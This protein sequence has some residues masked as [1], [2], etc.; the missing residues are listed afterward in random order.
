MFLSFA[1]S[2]SSPVL[3]G[4]AQAQEAPP[5]VGGRTTSDYE[6]VGLLAICDR[7]YWYGWYCSGT[8][9]HEDWV[10]TAAHCVEAGL[11]YKQREGLDTCFALGSNA[12]SNSGIDAVST[13]Q[14]MYAHPSYNSNN[15]SNDVGLLELKTPLRHLDPMA[16]NDDTI[17]NS[18]VGED[19]TW[20]GWGVTRQTANDSGVKRTVDVPIYT[21]DSNIVYTYAEGV[22]ICSGD[23]GGAAI[24]EDGG[25]RELVGVVSFGFNINGGSP[26]CHLSGAAGGAMRVDKYLSWFEDYV[27]SFVYADDGNTD[28]DTD[29]DTD[30]Q[31]TDT[32]DTDTQD[33]VID[34][35]DYV[36]GLPARPE[37]S[38][39]AGGGCSVQPVRSSGAS[40]WL[41]LG[42]AGLLRRRK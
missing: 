17:R 42:L 35:G 12:E 28:T 38:F 29:T 19:I 5:I 40:A 36:D 9:I 4:S 30:T 13:V 31:D 22:N 41:L 33:T 20:V 15:Y 37:P 21:Y 32:Q 2:L 1:L 25:V 23:S 8:L 10:A 26:D 24:M 39:V 16:V 7:N 14:N 6:Q 27:P 3:L 18:W 11:E 34:T